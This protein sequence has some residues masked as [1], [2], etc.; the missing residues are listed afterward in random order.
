MG[1]GYTED[2]QI[3][4]GSLIEVKLDEKNWS[5]QELLE[6]LQ[7]NWKLP[8]YIIKLWYTQLKTGDYFKELETLD[9]RINAAYIQQKGARL[10]DLLTMLDCSEEEIQT[11]E[12][13]LKKVNP[14]V[15][16]RTD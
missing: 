5:E 4:Y 12:Q 8:I 7:K 1:N 15:E 2:A 16:I 13:M 3:Y 14:K 11:L 6:G 10:W 9:K